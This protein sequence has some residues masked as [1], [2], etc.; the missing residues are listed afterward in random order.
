MAAWPSYPFAPDPS[1][2]V[3][4]AALSRWRDSRSTSST[5]SARNGSSARQRARSEGRS[6]RDPWVGV[7]DRLRQ[8]RRDARGGH[9]GARA[10]LRDRRARRAPWLLRSTSRSAR[11]TRSSVAGTTRCPISQ[12]VVATLL[13]LR[14]DHRD[15]ESALYLGERTRPTTRWQ[16]AR[17]DVRKVVDTWPKDTHFPHGALGR[18]SASPALK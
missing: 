7:G 10:C 16:T 18:R 6:A 13:D 9:R 4:R 3:L 2:D 11:S 17:G 8:L 12:R 14:R 1:I 5:R 15:R